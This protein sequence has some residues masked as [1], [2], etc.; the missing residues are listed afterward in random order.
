MSDNDLTDQIPLKYGEDMYITQ[1]DAHGVEQWTSQ[2]G[3]SRF[4]QFN[5]CPANERSCQRKI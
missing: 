3:L 1:Y 5:L 4:A 2:D